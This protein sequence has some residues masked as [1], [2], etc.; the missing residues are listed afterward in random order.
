MPNPL[1]DPTLTLNRGSQ[2]LTNYDWRDSQEAAIIATGHAPTNDLEA[3]ILIDLAPGAY[4]ASL[5]GARTT[6]IPG[7]AWWRSTI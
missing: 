7:S 4:T 2:D 5:R 3:A 6:A 1:H